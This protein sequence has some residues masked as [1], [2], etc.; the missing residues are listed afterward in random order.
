MKE[1]LAQRLASW[2]HR[3]TYEG[4][5]REVSTVARRALI[6]TIGVIAAGA[7]HEATLRAKKAYLMDSG[8]VPVTGGGHTTAGAAATIN[9]TAAHAY[10]FDDTS[11][12]GIMHASAIV[13]P[14]LLAAAPNAAITDEETVLAFI[15]G[16]EIAYVLA[17]VSTHQH[18]FRG[19]WSTST[20][21]LIGATAGVAKLLQLG[22]TET[23][24]ALSL[25]AAAAGG[26]RS[27]RGTD[28][29]P[30]LAGL[31]ARQALDIVLAA[32][33]GVTGPMD[34]FEQ[35]CGF[36]SL[37]L[38]GEPA[39]EHALTIGERWR[40][41]DPGLLF[42]RFPVCSA[43][44][45]AIE[46]TAKIC[47]DAEI[48]SL[49]ITRIECHVPHL[50]HI[51][52]V[53][54]EP[55]NPQEAQFSLPYLVAC[56]VLNGT[57]SFIDLERD[58]VHAPVVRALMAGIEVN[59]DPELSSEKAREQFP[60]SARII[61]E[62]LDG[63]RLSGFCGEALGMPNRPLTDA[64]ILAKFRTCVEHASHV[65]DAAVEHAGSFLAGETSGDRGIAGLIAAAWHGSNLPGD[66]ID[67]DDR[68]N[69]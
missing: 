42:K 60:E 34:V 68:R 47:H 50:V 13:V 39:L 61:I 11:Y 4:I 57:V 52:L 37:M 6:D 9:G 21:G 67:V 43:A 32:H 63:R 22:E 2:S 8:R 66:G 51:S 16:S 41:T 17:E 44:H 15:A 12:T 49:E 31:T 54:D 1:L 40:L 64:D 25:A 45:A 38:E 7:R 5:P 69:R 36:F 58:A 53:Y 35:P 10:D 46:Q 33:S 48:T 26:G 62:T 28:G 14:A 20:L 65:S 23:A 19:W 18:Y 55:A 24:C 56:A 27:L 30:L 59:V 29:K 3:L